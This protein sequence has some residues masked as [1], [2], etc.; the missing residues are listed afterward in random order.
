[1]QHLEL[2][3]DIAQKFNNR[4]QIEVFKIPKPIVSESRVKSLR[5]PLVKMS[6][7]D[8]QKDSCI[9]L[10]DTPE[11][12]KQKILR[13]VTDSDDG[14]QFD[15]VNRPGISSLI[16]LLALLQDISPQKVTENYKN[17][18]SF[19]KF[20]T[21]LADILIEMLEPIRRKYI[22]LVKNLDYVEALL[23]TGAEKA[24]SIA[25]RNLSFVKDIV[26]K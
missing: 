8:P 21:D 24:R 16:T 10:E 15:Q 22:D 12:I 1:M 5:N 6:K 4:Y 18:Q 2:V 19:F 23:T 17:D 14:I 25:A 26:F 7:S 9:F 13:A 20:K 11:L 3:C